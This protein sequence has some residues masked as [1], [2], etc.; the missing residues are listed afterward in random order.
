MLYLLDYGAGNVASLGTP[1]SA[2]QRPPLPPLTL[3]PPP[4]LFP[5]PCSQLGAQARLRV[6]VG[7]NARGHRQGRR[8][9]SSL[10]LSRRVC[11]V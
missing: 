6:Q 10:P 11:D 7:S 4:L 5:A 1:L 3:P 2:F 8:A 9:F